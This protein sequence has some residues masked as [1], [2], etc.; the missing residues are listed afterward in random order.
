MKYLI[1][2]Y[3]ILL[4]SFSLSAQEFQID[5]KN[6][7][8]Q[9]TFDNLK[10]DSIID[11][12]IEKYYVGYV[13]IST[14]AFLSGSLSEFLKSTV[15]SNAVNLKNTSNLFIRVN[16]LVIYDQLNMDSQTT[17]IEM[18]LSF[19]EN[20]N[21]TYYEVFQSAVNHMKNTTYAFKSIYLG[22]II[23]AFETSIS[24][25]L[26]R[27]NSGKLNKEN[28]RKINLYENPIESR[29]PYRIN[30]IHTFKKGI[31][32]SFYDFR[33]YNIDTLANFSVSYQNKKNNSGKAT[34]S[35]ISD[36]N[37]IKIWGFSDGKQNY[38]R[39]GTK[40][41]PL[42]LEDSVFSVNDFPKETLV[43]TYTLFS[44]FGLVGALAGAVIANATNGESGSTRT[45]THEKYS[46]NFNNNKFYPSNESGE[47]KME[48][49]IVLIS[50]QFNKSDSKIEVFIDGKKK[51]N[52]S[53]ANYYKFDFKP[54]KKDFEICVVYNGNKV[55]YTSH[56]LLFNSELLLLIANGKKIEINKANMYI[57]RELITAIEKYK[58][59]KVN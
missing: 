24:Q 6:G 48:G 34:I 51:C 35:G 15:S 16:K 2:F 13:N 14:P 42:S 49:N 46:L 8:Q 45:N 33:D 52:L 38:C 5:L 28:E 37:E 18:N 20:R 31:Y 22:N 29:I 9:L 3:A 1:T 41:Y 11:G 26:E 19:I 47:F 40:F 54:G 21:G 10:I 59:S 17:N 32:N 36:D 12:R 57:K 50:S 55:C 44:S 30:K 4:S 56:P 23:Y 53:K 25:Y 39:L 27:R 58:I 7:K 43:S